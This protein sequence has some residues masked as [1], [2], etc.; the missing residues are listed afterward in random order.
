MT[1]K[2]DRFKERV[3]AK[4]CNQLVKDLCKLIR[5]YRKSVEK[6]KK[7]KRKPKIDIKKIAELLGAEII[8]DPA[9]IAEIKKK[10]YPWRPK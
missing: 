3:N 2:H 10:A 6:N 7:I 9:K 4:N 1:T 5:Q 8:T